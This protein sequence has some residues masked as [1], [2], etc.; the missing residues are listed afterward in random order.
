MTDLTA[1]RSSD[2]RGGRSRRRGRR[3]AVRRVSSPPG[4]GPAPRAAGRQ[5]RLGRHSRPG[6]RRGPPRAAGGLPVPFVPAEQPR[7]AVMLDDGSRLPGRHDGMARLRSGPGRTTFTLIRNHEENGRRDRA[8]GAPGTRLRHGRGAAPPPCGDRRR[9]SADSAA[10]SA[11][12][13]MNCSGGAD[14]VGL[15]GDLRGDRQRLRRR[16]RLHPRHSG[17]TTR[18]GHHRNA[19]A[20]DARLHLRGAGA[21][22]GERGA[23]HPA[24]PV[25]TSRWRSTRTPTRSTSA[26]TTSP[27][28]AASTS[29]SRRPTR[30]ERVG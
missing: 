23:D 12:T 4:R 13:Q 7:R 26:R 29:T 16:R 30:A 19:A 10:A 1:V 22:R 18:P 9:R 27:S 20:E 14:A 24:R 3:R 15:V 8:L 28:R 21:R 11:G 5:A 25:R 6:R 2:R 17:G